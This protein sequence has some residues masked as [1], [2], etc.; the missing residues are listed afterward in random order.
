MAVA[1]PARGRARLRL[2]LLVLV[3]AVAAA[4]ATA[5]GLHS[6][7]QLGDLG[8]DGPAIALLFLLAGSVAVVCLVPASV[9]AAAAGYLLGAT[10][11]TAVAIVAVTVGSLAAFGLARWIGGE[12]LV[13]LGGP[14]LRAFAE[15]VERRGF[16][17]V[18]YA[19]LIPGAPFTYL[20][21]LAGLTRISATS[22]TAATALG[23]APRALVYATVGQQLTDFDAPQ[24]RIAVALMAMLAVIGA[25][26]YLLDRRAAARCR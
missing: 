2:A 4:A 7:E 5:I 17:A 12:P 20:N 15:R 1:R 10:A 21:Y 9:V 24:V 26:A 3:M 11:G 22:F 14:R 8:E 23:F 19:R 18:L 13:H 25:V 6:S 16:L